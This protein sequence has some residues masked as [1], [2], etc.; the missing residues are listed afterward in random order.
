MNLPVT[1]INRPSRSF[2]KISS[3][4]K[5]MFVNYVFNQLNNSISFDVSTLYDYFNFADICVPSITYI[6]RT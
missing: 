3:N 2:R 1:Q 4:D 5:P 6:N